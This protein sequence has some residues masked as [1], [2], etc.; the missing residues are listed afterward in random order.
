MIHA[1]TRRIA[2]LTKKGCRKCPA[3][4][5]F[6]HVG[7]ASAA[8]RWLVQALLTSMAQA[9]AEP[10]RAVN[11]SHAFCD[12]CVLL[13][14][15]LN[16]ALP[17]VCPQSKCRPSGTVSSDDAKKNTLSKQRGLTECARQQC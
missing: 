13:M 11:D 17:P 15:V 16:G 2:D 7:V 3:W 8:P 9:M 1:G 6:R 10:S 5:L 12:G 14:H 4:L